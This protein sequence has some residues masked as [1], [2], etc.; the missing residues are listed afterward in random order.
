MGM[1][2]LIG[3]SACTPPYGTTFP[4]YAGKG[5][6]REKGDDHQLQNNWKYSDV[7][8]IVLLEIPIGE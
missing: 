7:D 3:S 1:Q 8:G 6:L 2:S 4:K 5:N